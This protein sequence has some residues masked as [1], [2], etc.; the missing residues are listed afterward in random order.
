MKSFDVVEMGK[1]SLIAIVSFCK[2]V[3]QTYD[4]E[5]LLF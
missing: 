4:L 5:V 3:E 1:Y 2:K